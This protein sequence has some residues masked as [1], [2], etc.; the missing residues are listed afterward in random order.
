MDGATQIVF[1]EALDD[2]EEREE[3]DEEGE[4]GEIFAENF[5]HNNFH[6]YCKH[7]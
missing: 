6:C 4:E 2:G 7:F 3:E 1:A 5:I